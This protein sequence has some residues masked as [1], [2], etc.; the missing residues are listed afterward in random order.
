[1]SHIRGEEVDVRKIK[2]TDVFLGADENGCLVNF[3][4][5]NFE[6]NF[7]TVIEESECEGASLYK[8]TAIHEF[9][10]KKLKSEDKSVKITEK[11]SCI[12]FSVEIGDVTLENVGSGENIYKGFIGD[13]HFFKRAKSKNNTVKVTSID[14]G[15]TLNFETNIQSVGS[16]IPIYNFDSGDKVS[17]LK[18]NS[19]KIEKHTDGT[20][21]IDA[22]DFNYLKVYYVNSNYTPT[23]IS[24]ADGSVIRPFPTFEEAISTVIGNGTIVS[25]QNKNAK[26]VVQTDSQTEIN[27]TVNTTTIELQNTTLLYTGSDPY[28]FDSE[29]LYPMLPKNAQNEITSSV[30][31]SVIGRGKLIRNNGVGILRSIGSKRTSANTAN[32]NYI[33][34]SVSELEDDNITVLENTN[35]PDSIWE[36]DIMMP[37]GVTKIGD[38]FNPPLQMKWTTQVNPTNPIIYISGHNFNSFVYPSQGQGKITITTF[39]NTALYV[40]D[41]IVSWEQLIIDTSIYRISTL[42]GTVWQNGYTG[43]YQPKDFPAIYVENSALHISE[44]YYPNNGTP[45]Y[46]GW[47]K[48]IKIVGTFGFTG[49]FS[50]NTFYFVETFIDATEFTRN[51][52][53]LNSSLAFMSIRSNIKNFIN[54]SGEGNFDIVIPNS[55]ISGVDVI[56][57]NPDKNIIPITHG[58]I[59]SIK[60]VPYISGISSFANDSAANAGGLITNAI[61][62]NSTTNS[63]TVV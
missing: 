58:T 63:I 8:E 16:G 41:T 46:C 51:S 30:K 33:S 40:K 21:F 37:D 17:S 54:T 20:I 50:F 3:P 43:I 59:S 48:F 9:T 55:I 25:P 38:S 1:M 7:D 56:S 24:P 31:I 22:I 39:A 19:L 18:S 57:Q 61:Y 10:F 28:M 62:M 60:S 12:D 26:I 23:S 53:V 14:G 47:K 13:K 4:P 5:E 42:S 35:Y 32:T 15:D 45:S 36:G 44:I 52:L 2:P 6:F 27:P 49:S 11:D 34:I 29:K